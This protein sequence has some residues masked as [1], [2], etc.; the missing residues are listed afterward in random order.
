VIKEIK[1]VI[2]KIDIPD[3]TVEERDQGV[4]LTLN[5]IH[6]VADKETILASEKPRLDSL[7]ETL[8]KIEGRTFLVVG[9]TAKSG[10]EAEQRELSI[11]R[12][13]AIVDYLAS[14]GI[15]AKRFLY[16]GR[17]ATEPIAPNDTEQNMAKNRRVEIIIL[18]D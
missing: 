5:N 2:A 1:E 10:T 4:A 11:K 7:A 14:K 6:F 17:G 16:E 8:K 13:K 12:A 18:E 15:D 9:H 3:V